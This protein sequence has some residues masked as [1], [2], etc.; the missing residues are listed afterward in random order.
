MRSATEGRGRAL[1]VTVLV[2]AAITVLVAPSGDPAGAEPEPVAGVVGVAAGS[3]HTCAL[4]ANGT[5]KCWGDNSAGQLGLGDALSRGRDP[6][7]MGATLSTVDLG[8][9]RTATQITASPTSS[10]TTSRPSTSAPGVP[11]PTSSP[12]PDEAPPPARS[13]TTAP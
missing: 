4:R 11:P 7:T 3:G 1:L 13:S 5:V 12:G 6:G 2:L 10:A 9:G 8:A